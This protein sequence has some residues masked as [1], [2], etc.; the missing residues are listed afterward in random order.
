MKLKGKIVDTTIIVL[1]W[2]GTCLTGITLIPQSYKVF[3]TKD[4]K[5][6]SLLMMLIIILASI[7]WIIYAIL[8]YQIAIIVTNSMVLVSAIFILSFK[9]YNIIKKNEKI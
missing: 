9:I 8:S 1:S 4:T 3:K 5:A 2:I 7:I 6:I